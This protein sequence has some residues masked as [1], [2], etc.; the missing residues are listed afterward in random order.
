MNTVWYDYSKIEARNGT[1]IA[2]GNFD[3]LHQGHMKLLSMLMDV[4]QDNGLHSVVYTFDTHPINALKGE[5]TLKL[6]ADNEYKQELLSS[7]G[8]DTLF[9]EKFDAVRDLSPEDFVRDILV[10]KLNMKVA[11]VGLHNHYGKDSKGDV[12]LLRELGQKYGFLVYM[13]KPLYFGDFLCSS[14]K[15]RALIENGEVEKASELLGR[16]FK[17]KNTVVKDKMLGRTLGYP[18]ANMIPAS[19]QLVP[20]FGVYGTTT[21]VDGVAY[22]SITNVG[23]S[24]TVGDGAVRFETY[25]IGFDGDVYN[26]KLEVEFLYRIRDLCAF[27]NLDELKA[28][29]EADEKARLA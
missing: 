13:I 3:G 5:N 21:Y 12:K 18:T 7:C 8:L 15:I 20:K 9:F 27:Q 10:G 29:L 16:P 6:I 14:T 17:I 28:Q 1:A 4:S 22:K 26:E 24:P 23:D 25:I 11:V 19:N 2:L